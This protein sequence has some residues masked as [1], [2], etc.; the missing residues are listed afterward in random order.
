MRRLVMPIFI[1]ATLALTAI[2]WVMSDGQAFVFILPL[3]LGLPFLWRRR[4]G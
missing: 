3:I 4:R 1:L 2:V